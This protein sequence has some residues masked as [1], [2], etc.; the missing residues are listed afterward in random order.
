MY[1]ISLYLGTISV[2]KLIYW[3]RVGKVLIIEFLDPDLLRFT[4][5]SLFEETEILT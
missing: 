5:H 3:T 4:I 2:G 1:T